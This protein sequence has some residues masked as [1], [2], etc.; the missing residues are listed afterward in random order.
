[1]QPFHQGGVF[2][3]GQAVIGKVQVDVGI[4]DGA[5]ADVDKLIA[6]IKCSKHFLY[7]QFDFTQP[8]LMVSGKFQ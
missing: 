7:P 1:M 8:C 4:H 3:L 6:K 2:L 5:L